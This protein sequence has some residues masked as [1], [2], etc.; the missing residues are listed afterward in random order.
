MPI[1][2]LYTDYGIEIAPE[3]HKHQRE[4]WVNIA[5]PHCTGSEGYHL[6]F[7]DGGYVFTC[8]RCGSHFVD[9]TLS[10]LLNVNYKQAGSIAKDYKIGKKSN[11]KKEYN[12]NIRINQNHSSIHPGFPRWNLSIKSTWRKE[13]LTLIILQIIGGCWEQVHQ[14]CWIIFLINIGSWLL[15]IGRMRL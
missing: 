4:G 8:W 15:Y 13:G 6:G 9:K 14:A 1:E 7:S 2:D 10:I 12:S 3:G 5:C 11:T